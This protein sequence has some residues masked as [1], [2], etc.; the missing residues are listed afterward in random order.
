M[1]MDSFLIVK[2]LV[3]L[4]PYANYLSNEADKENVV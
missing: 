4:S 1:E 2:P 3:Y